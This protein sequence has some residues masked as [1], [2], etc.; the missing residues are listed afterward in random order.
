MRHDREE[1]APRPARELV[2]KALAEGATR[3][4]AHD[5]AE[6]AMD[7]LVVVRPRALSRGAPRGDAIHLLDDALDDLLGFRVPRGAGVALD[8]LEQRDK[9]VRVPQQHFVQLA[10]SVG[11]RVEERLTPLHRTEPVRLEELRYLGLDLFL[12]RIEA[13]LTALDALNK[14]AHGHA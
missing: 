10:E 2:A 8:L 7:V 5:V 6:V 1:G 9:V 11:R 14:I 12:L 3:I 13:P 4:E